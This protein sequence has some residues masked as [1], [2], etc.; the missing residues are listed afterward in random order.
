MAT[1]TNKCVERAL[2]CDVTDGTTVTTR[3]YAKDKR[4][5][6]E[7]RRSTGIASYNSS[8][9]RQVQFS[10]QKSV[11]EDTCHTYS[12]FKYIHILNFKMYF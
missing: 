3:L 9:D 10:H 12:I 2:A 5:M 4:K 8:S 6:R 1:D 7:K 11:F